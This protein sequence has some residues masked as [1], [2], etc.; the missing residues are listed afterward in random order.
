[1]SSIKPK[2]ILLGIAVVM[3]SLFLYL[4]CVAPDIIFVSNDCCEGCVEMKSVIT[5]LEEEGFTVKYIKG[6]TSSVQELPTI[7]IRGKRF[8]GVLDIE[9]IRK[10]L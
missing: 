8:T 9:E 5:Q 4:H 2:D 7:I 1:M 3:M 10:L 6:P